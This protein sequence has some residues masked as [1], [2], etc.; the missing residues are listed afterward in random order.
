[1]GVMG[2]VRVGCVV[3]VAC[4]ECVVLCN[5]RMLYVYLVWV[6]YICMDE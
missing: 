3:C 1:M 5:V 2:S 6:D 4:V